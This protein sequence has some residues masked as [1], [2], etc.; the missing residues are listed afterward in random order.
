M[1]LEIRHGDLLRQPV[2]VIVNAWNQNRLPWWLLRPHGISGAIKRAAGTAPFRELAR[3]GRMAL[4]AAVLTSAGR[5]PYRGIIHT[6][7][8]T[9]AGRSSD[10]IIR[11][12]VE[13]TM[14]LVATHGFDSVGFPVLGSGSGQLTPRHALD[15]MQQTLGTIDYPGRVV[16][17]VYGAGQPAP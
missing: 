7:T 5:L 10:Q 2:E 13:Q 17:V 16:I 6:A 9:R 15:V 11:S 14:A 4:G 3:H 8:I 12:A 1:Q